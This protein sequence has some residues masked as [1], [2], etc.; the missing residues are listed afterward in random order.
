MMV[1]T[2]HRS[3]SIIASMRLRRS[4]SGEVSGL[5]IAVIGLSVLVMG[6]GSFAIWAYVN[7]NEAQSSLDQKIEIAKSDARR[8]QA[9]KDAAAEAERAKSPYKNF[10]AP[11]EYCSLRFKYPQSWSQFWAKKITNGGDFEAYLHPEI[12]QP[13]SPTEK[14][15]LRVL[16]EQKDFDKVMTQY[17]NDINRGSLKQSSGSSNGEPYTMLRGDF[18][19]DIRGIAVI[20]GCRDKTITVRTDAYTFE[21]DFNELVRTIEFN[22]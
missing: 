3:I 17:Y 11:D 14:F 20:Y 18:S 4:E 1:F 22:S 2:D 5:M 21:N 7:Y 8:E 15:A 6:L 13:I 9:E 10:K 12:I 16:I 19:K